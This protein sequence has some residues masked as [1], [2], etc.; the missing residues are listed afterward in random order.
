[1]KAEFRK[2]FKLKIEPM[3]LSPVTFPESPGDAVSSGLSRL[4]LE[5]KQDGQENEEAEKPVYR[6]EVS[7]RMLP[8]P[9]RFSPEPE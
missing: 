4:P 3:R 8:N 7:T 2:A 9:E 1:M 5:M 6:S